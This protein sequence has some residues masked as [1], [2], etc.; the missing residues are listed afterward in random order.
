MSLRDCQENIAPEKGDSRSLNF[1]TKSLVQHVENLPGHV[2][3]ISAL[4]QVHN[5][6]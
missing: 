4:P 2:L 5:K 3:I 1:C 6:D